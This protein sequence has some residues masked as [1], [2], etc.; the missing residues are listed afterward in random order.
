MLLLKNFLFTL[1]VP[2]SIALWLPLW[3]VSLE[4]APIAWLAEGE[5]HLLGLI[6]A[7]MGLAG[8]F[9]CL[10]DFM[11]VGRGTPAP[12][13]PPTRLVVRGLYR[14][15]RNPMYVSV[16][17]LLAGE[18]ILTASGAL[19]GYA[20]LVVGIWHLFV[21][22]YE[23]PTLERRFGDEYRAYRAK[24]RRWLPRLTPLP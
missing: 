18:V 17:L 8:Y 20:V 14:F 19:A 5:R 2:G 15:V 3:I 9:A 12:I 10:S 11:T 6:P 24:V 23:E 21:V 4:A 7:A 16:G 13:D 22:F 1:I